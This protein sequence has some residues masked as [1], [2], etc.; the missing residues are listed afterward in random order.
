MNGYLM[1]WITL[2]FIPLLGQTEE[3]KIIN[4]LDFGV[5]PDGKTLNTLLIQRAIN[6]AINEKATLVFPE[7]IYLSGALVLG[8]NITFQ[9]NEGATLLASPD[10]NHYPDKVFLKA[11]FAHNLT[12]QGRG[13]IDGNGSAFFD[14]N[15]NFKE[16]PEPF[17]EIVDSKNVKLLGFNLVNSP[18]HSINFSFCEAILVDGLTINNDP[19]SPNTDGIDLVNTRNVTIRN[20]TI[21]TGDD[22]ICLKN[23]R[24]QEDWVDANGSPRPKIT[25]NI[26]VHSCYLESDDAALKLGTGSGYRTQNV[27][28]DDITIRNTRYAIGLFM[29]DGGLY[30]NILFK[31]I[32]AETGSR[33]PQEY[34]VF[35]DIHQRKKDSKVGR[36]QGITFEDCSFTTKGIFYLSGHPQQQV[37]DI[38]FKNVNITF[39]DNL[40]T[41]EWQKP[42]GNK[43]IKQWK[44]TSDY[45]R[46][47]AKIIVAHAEKVE[48]NSVTIYKAS[49]NYPIIWE[50]EAKI[51]TTNFLI[52]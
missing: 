44:S 19:M 3:R 47:R 30:E 24:Y 32:N 11:S 6:Q 51:D 31:N 23:T 8:E 46:K 9:I 34:A 42:K 2:F 22:A 26:Q 28:F 7:G 13:T 14:A 49:K 37:K 48:F 10:I 18:A 36:I 38:A 20:C 40:N 35:M 21:T 39:T 1:V 4:V 52:Q 25:E 43:T 5:V 16:R 17:I 50:R 29:M 33:H 27:I 41:V 45:T 15:W 12:I